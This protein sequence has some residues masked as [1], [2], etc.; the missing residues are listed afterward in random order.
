[1]NHGSKS[2]D[3]Q[4]VTGHLDG[5]F[6]HLPVNALAALLRA[7]VIDLPYV[8]ERLPRASGK[9]LR[10]QTVKLPGT[11]HGAHVHA[12]RLP[13]QGRNKGPRLVQ[14]HVALTGLLRVIKRMAVQK[15]PHKLA[16]DVLQA[17][18]EVGVLKDGVVAAVEGG[19]AD[20]E[21]LFLGDLIRRDHPG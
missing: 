6:L 4:N 13:G 8:V 19:G 16:G 15:V 10:E 11:L 12:L 18:L 20:G 3:R 1:M 17:E 5:F 7:P 21:A 14:A 9:F 2:G